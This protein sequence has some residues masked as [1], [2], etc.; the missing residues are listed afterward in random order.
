M[1]PTERR[2]Q[3][4]RPRVFYFLRGHQNK[5]VIFFLPILSDDRGKRTA[6]QTYT[7]DNR[8]NSIQYILIST[9]YGNEILDTVTLLTTL[10]HA[11]NIEAQ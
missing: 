11:R 2:R 10:L 9:V 5:T 6:G 7:L 3:W 1:G 4:L 8:K